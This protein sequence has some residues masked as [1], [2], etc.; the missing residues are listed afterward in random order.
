MTTIYI[1]EQCQ[2]CARYLVDGGWNGYKPF[3]KA[4][5][6]GIPEKIQSGQHNHIKK[7]NGDGGILFKAINR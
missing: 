2:R 1:S 5:K 7:F 3:C 4:F 6:N